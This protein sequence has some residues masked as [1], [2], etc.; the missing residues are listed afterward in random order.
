MVLICFLADS[1]DQLQQMM[2]RGGRNGAVCQVWL[3]TYGGGE[4][5]CYQ[6]A[7]DGCIR[8]QIQLEL[9]GADLA[10]SCEDRSSFCS[11]CKVNKESDCEALISE[12]LSHL[13]VG[14]VESD[15]SRLTVVPEVR[16]ALD[17]L[18]QGKIV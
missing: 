3:L 17:V 14:A 2:C 15:V 11:W 4:G 8:Q 6:Y 10:R 9:D 5:S 1:V 18:N 13:S 16:S 7:K 12:E